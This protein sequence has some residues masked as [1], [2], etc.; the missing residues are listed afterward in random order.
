MPAVIAAYCFYYLTRPETYALVCDL[1]QANNATARGVVV[2]PSDVLRSL[3][4]R[5]G[6][7]W[8]FWTPVG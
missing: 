2:I 6:H 5:R 1:E 3:A 8:V 4:D 7:C